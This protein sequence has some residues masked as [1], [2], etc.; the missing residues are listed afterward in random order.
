[1]TPT[2]SFT[3]YY[4]GYVMPPVNPFTRQAITTPITLQPTVVNLVYFPLI[5]IVFQVVTNATTPPTPLPGFVVAAYSSVT[6]QKMFEGISNGTTEYVANGHIVGF[7]LPP[8]NPAYWV[9][10]LRHRANN[11]CAN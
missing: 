6:G 1:V 3:L 5:D 4:F 10:Q 2:A 11:E 8:P 7:Q 9:A